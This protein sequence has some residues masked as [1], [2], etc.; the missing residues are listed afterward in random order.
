MQPLRPFRYVLCLVSIVFI[1]GCNQHGEKATSAAAVLKD[2]TATDFPFFLSEKTMILNE[3]QNNEVEGHYLK[4]LQVVSDSVLRINLPVGFYLKG[5]DCSGWMLG[6][7]TGNAYYDAANENLRQIQFIDTNKNQVFLGKLLRGSGHPKKNQRVVF[8]NRA[9]SGFKNFRLGKMVRP[10]WWK[11]FAGKSIE[12]GGV[13]FDS[14]ARHWIMYVQEVDTNHVNIYAATSIDFLKWNAFNKGM[15]IFQAKDFMDGIWGGIAD[16]G[17]TPQSAKLYSVIF[18]KGEYFFFLCGYG[19]DQK[20]HIGLITSHDPLKGPFIIHPKP[21]ISPDSNSYDANGCF[22]PKV[23]RQGNKYLLYYDGIGT[24]GIER[25]CMAES[26][27]LLQWKKNPKNPVIDK[28][29]GWRSGPFTSE[30]NHIEC[31]N[32]TVWLMLAGYKKYNTEFNVTDSIYDRLPKDTSIFNANE[33][34]KGKHISGNVM[35]AE[36]GVFFS[37][38]GGYT[39]RPHINNPV[40]INDYSDTLQNDHLGGDFFHF[41]SPAGDYILYQ[42]KSETQKRY[43][44]L[45][46]ER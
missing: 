27:D 23:C 19:S 42:A 22:Y 38:D 9:P 43:N 24:D 45:L 26:N 10:E 44:I 46:R 12:F 18:E 5:K 34:E 39:F 37:T 16:D 8:W 31:H 21:L 40:W 29:Y 4:V 13:V 28:H 6:W 7:P 1:V 14:I 32:D 36:L 17:K 35:D 2:T 20:R 25:L 3:E 11:A 41:K 15:S 33:S 30:P